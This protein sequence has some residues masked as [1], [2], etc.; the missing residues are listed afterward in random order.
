ME[1]V[2]RGGVSA[3]VSEGECC[4]SVIRVGHIHE[5]CQNNFHSNRMISNIIMICAYAATLY[6]PNCS[7]LSG[8]VR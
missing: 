3:E 8:D 1:D 5:S 2:Q 4:N 6:L 7:I